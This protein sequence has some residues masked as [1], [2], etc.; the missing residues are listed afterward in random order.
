MIKKIMP[1]VLA[2]FLLFLPGKAQAGKEYVAERFDVDIVVKDGGSMQVIETITFR[3][4][5]GPFTYVYRDLDNKRTDGISYTSATLDGKPLP[6]NAENALEWV[7]VQ[8]G[9]PLTVTWHFTPTTD[10]T[11]V[12]QLTYQ[13]DGVVRKNKTDDIIWMVIPPEHEYRSQASRITVSYPSGTVLASQPQLTGTNSFIVENDGNPVILTAGPVEAETPLVM[14]LNFTP[15]TLIS[16]APVW[17]AFE[18]AR[19][20]QAARR[21]PFTIGGFLIAFLGLI[22]A[23]LVT[24]FRQDPTDVAATPG[25]APSQTSPPTDYK[26]AVAAAL[27]ARASPSLIHSLAALIDLAQRGYVAIEQVPGKWYS[28]NR[29]ELVKLPKT[30][31]LSMHEQVLMDA[32]FVK[33]GRSVERIRLDQYAQLV[34]THISEFSKAVKVEIGMLGLISPV[35]KKRQMRFMVT[36]ACLILA[37]LVFGMVWVMLVDVRP[38]GM[39]SLAQDQFSGAF[40]GGAIAGFVGG[41]V[42]LIFGALYS[43]LTSQGQSIASKWNA[44]SG[45]LKDITAQREEPVAPDTFTVYLPFAAGFGLGTQWAKSFQKRGYTDVPGWFHAL[46]AQDATGSFGAFAAF[47]S[48]SDSS[49][50]SSS[51]GGGGGASGGGGSGAG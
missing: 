5:G 6:V 21:A 44:F 15:G 25:L 51:G 40:L 41:F 36:G 37:G 24:A 17:Q 46:N 39:L 27:A 23:L 4:M 35:R 1:W 26:P 13:V 20:E 28:P 47:M 9:D 49:A 12:F 2:V 31:T 3:F 11:R 45:Y 43:P 16:T 32:L 10:Q 33:N 42:Y 29:F 38:A 50:A 19:A 8:E 22:S 48:S 7:E 30:D 18:T 14:A 34:A